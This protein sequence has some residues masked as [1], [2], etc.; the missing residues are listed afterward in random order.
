MGRVCRAIEP[1]AN[2]FLSFAQ[3]AFMVQISTRHLFSTNGYAMI[4]KALAAV[5][6][7]FMCTGLPAQDYTLNPGARGRGGDRERRR[8]PNA[9]RQHAELQQCDVFGLSGNSS[10]AHIHGP[11]PATGVLF[12]W[13]D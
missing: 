1:K 6:L 10:A 7:A 12:T 8:R 2:R 11:L 13:P 5:T 9:H 4:K 3:G